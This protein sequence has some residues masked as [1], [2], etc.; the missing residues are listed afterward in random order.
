MIVGLLEESKRRLVVMNKP[1]ETAL[2]TNEERNT[3]AGRRRGRKKKKDKGKDKPQCW[4]C[5][6][7]SHLRTK[8]QSWL[9][10]TD[11]GR[12]Y[13]AEHPESGKAR[14]GPLP[15]PGAKGN[16]S[17]ER[18]EVVAEPC[19]EV[20]WEAIKSPRYRTDWIVDLGATRHMTP[21]RKAFI[22]Y[23]TVKDWPVETANGTALPSIGIGK[24]RLSVRAD[25]H[26]RSVLLTDVL[27]ILEIR[28]NLISI[29]KL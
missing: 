3:S 24:V 20:C 4:H 14:T 16:L 26:T 8:C 29:T 2:Q 7:E 18:A 21:N 5:K 10:D 6:S 22:E 11:E 9:R 27:H 15:T 17:P 25:G 13:A 19:R 23:S 12:E 1:V 28:G